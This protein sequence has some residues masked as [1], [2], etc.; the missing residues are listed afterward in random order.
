MS[1]V[2]ITGDFNSLDINEGNIV[3][4]DEIKHVKPRGLFHLEELN[5]TDKQKKFI[6]LCLDANTRIIL[7]KGPAGSSKTLT[8]VYSALSLL[9]KGRVEDIIYMRSAVESSDAKLGF[10]P[11]DA[12][13][14]LFYYN[15]PFMDKLDELLNESAIKKLQKEDRIKIH[16]VNFARGMSWN[17]KAIVFDEAQNS[18]LKEI[19][20]VLTRIGRYSRLFVMADPMQTDLKHNKGGFEKVYDLFDDEES[21]EKGIYTFEFTHED[22]M[23][24]ELTKYVVSRLTEIEQ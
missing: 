7:C 23:R 12:E 8:G 2:R 3:V 21:R 22:I 10:L 4:S 24:S 9:N 5:W 19:V 13:D 1:K 11:G 6:E 16:P 15:L 18:S 17:Q 14:K 20:T